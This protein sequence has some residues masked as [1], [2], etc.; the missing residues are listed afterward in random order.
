MDHIGYKTVGLFV[1]LLL[2]VLWIILDIL[3]NWLTGFVWINAINTLSGFAVLV[4]LVPL[5][6]WIAHF[7]YR[8]IFKMEETVLGEE[9]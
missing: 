3:K 2:G 4:L 6:P 8:L 5:I 9:K 7:L 1:G